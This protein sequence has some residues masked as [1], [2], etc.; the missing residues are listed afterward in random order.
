MTAETFVFNYLW[1]V[2]MTAGAGFWLY[3]LF[4]KEPRT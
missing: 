2:L 4:A 3:V 1:P